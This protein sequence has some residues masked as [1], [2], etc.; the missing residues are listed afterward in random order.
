MTFIPEPSSVDTREVS[1]MSQSRLLLA[2]EI[3]PV[4]TKEDNRTVD[5]SA[6][7]VL[8]LDDASQLTIEVNGLTIMI[9][10]GEDSTVLC[11]SIML[12]VNGVVP[13]TVNN[14]N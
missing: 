3:K 4:T 9:S 5:A 6:R 11:L 2:T 1:I 14:T 10:L 13:N 8:Q 7:V 12:P